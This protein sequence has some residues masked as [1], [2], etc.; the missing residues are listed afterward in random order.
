MNITDHPGDAILYRHPRYGFVIEGAVQGN[1][2][3]LLGKH[4]F[5][6]NEAGVLALP[7]DTPEDRGHDML[8]CAAYVLAVTG[9]NFTVLPDK[10]AVEWARVQEALKAL[11]G[12]RDRALAMVRRVHIIP[13]CLPVP[14]ISVPASRD[15][16]DVEYQ[17]VYQNLFTEHGHRAPRWVAARD[18]CAH[19]PA[20]T[21]LAIYEVLYHWYQLLNA[22]LRH[23][24]GNTKESPYDLRW[25]AERLDA[26]IAAVAPAPERNIATEHATV[27]ELRDG[28]QFSLDSGQHWYMCARDE[29]AAAIAV[30][31]GEHDVDG[32]PLREYVDAEPGQACLIRRDL[33]A[34]PQ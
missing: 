27:A 26:A 23:I 30:F 21:V 2:A 6:L 34:Q 4:G 25:C 15:D 33:T 8:D 32:V 24:D 13:G 18:S 7:L 5:V 9:H 31:T 10:I 1:A 22:A 16:F 17:A 20:N 3:A 28:D 12:S 11:A 29:P 19:L 14:R